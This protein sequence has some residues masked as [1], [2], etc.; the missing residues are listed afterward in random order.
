MKR[1]SFSLI[2]AFNRTK[3]DC[4]HTANKDWIKQNIGPKA[5]ITSVKLHLRQLY[6]FKRINIRCRT[7]INVLE[8]GINPRGSQMYGSLIC[9]GKIVNERPVAHHRQVR[10]CTEEGMTSMHVSVLPGGLA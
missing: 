5:D 8:L 3:D 9:G 4:R 1:D 7:I 6:I 10:L 2:L